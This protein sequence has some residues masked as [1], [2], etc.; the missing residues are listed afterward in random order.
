MRAPG[1][2]HWQELDKLLAYINR[3]KTW[4]ILFGHREHEPDLGLHGYTD[5][6]HNDCPDTSRASVGY[7]HR[8]FSDPISWSSKIHAFV[9]TCVN[10]SEYGALAKGTQR[11]TWLVALY[12]DLYKVLEP[13][14]AFPAIKPVVVFTDNAGAISLAYGNVFHGS[15]QYVRNSYHYAKEAQAEG[16]VS[17]KWISSNQQRA[18]YLTKGLTP[19]MHDIEVDS[20]VAPPPEPGQPLQY[21]LKALGV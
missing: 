2:K 4:G 15:N 8:F 5:S 16:L 21:N 17:F 10:H 3:T 18:N 12:T 13:G 6:S 20:Y 19:Q 7:L 14:H 11:M 9:T 1:V